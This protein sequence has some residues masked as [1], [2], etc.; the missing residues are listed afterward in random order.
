MLEDDYDHGD[1]EDG[2]KD[3]DEDDDKDDE[4]Y[5]KDDDGD[6]DEKKTKWPRAALWWRMANTA[7]ESGE[8][9]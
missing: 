5:D 8:L 2:N 9:F 6:D 3:D 4:V 1:D 7:P